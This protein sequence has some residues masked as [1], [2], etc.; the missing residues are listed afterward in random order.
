MCVYS[1]EWS[2]VFGGL[3]LSS[4]RFHGR[5]LGCRFGWSWLGSSAASLASP[6]LGLVLHLVSSSSLRCLRSLSLSFPRTYSFV[7]S[8]SSALSQWF[9]LP[10]RSPRLPASLCLS[11]S[12]VITMQDGDHKEETAVHPDVLALQAEM[13]LLRAAADNEVDNLRAQLAAAQASAQ[14]P[15]AAH[16]GQPP[17]VVNITTPRVERPRLAP[18]TK[19]AGA[20]GT[21]LDEW[22]QDM[23]NQFAYYPSGFRTDKEKIL[24][25][26]SC[27]HGAAKTWWKADP[28]HLSI[29]TWAQF[30]ATMQARFRPVQAAHKARMQ[31]LVMRQERGQDLDSFINKFQQVM[32]QIPDMS[33][34]DK[35]VQFKLALYRPIGAKVHEKDPQTLAAAIDAASSING[36]FAGLGR[37]GG[38]RR[39]SLLPPRH[40]VAGVAARPWIS[41]RSTSSSKSRIRSSR[42]PPPLQPIACLAPTSM[43]KWRHESTRSWQHTWVA[44]APLAALVAE[45]QVPLVV[46]TATW[47]V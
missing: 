12:L 9:Q 46:E 22:E 26:T 5:W 10:S 36:L 7:E 24:L 31:L 19:Y 27:L 41:A 21:A 28:T 38:G 1:C 4:C 37:D 35:V 45:A 15:L 42:T 34:A 17:Q 8:P 3:C 30:M 6:R 47:M 23:E 32:A 44:T 43:H 2:Y 29:A 40:L 20:L 18:A 11:H 13:A 39:Q 16:A 14:V 33:E 25:A